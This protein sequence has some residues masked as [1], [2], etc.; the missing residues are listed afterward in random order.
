MNTKYMNSKTIQ[1]LKSTDLFQNIPE[2]DIIDFFK[3]HPV[4][5][6]YQKGSV[7]YLQN[8]LCETLDII[9]KGTVTIQKIDYD[10]KILT[11]N[12][13]CTG[14]ILGENL[15]FSTKNHYPMTVFAT[16]NTELVQIKAGAILD[17]CQRSRIFLQ[18]LLE[19]LSG[20]T[21]ILS[22]RLK[23]S[24]KSIRQILSEFL[25]YESYHQ[26]TLTIHL[27]SSK[28][29]LAEKMGIQRSSLSR[30]LN[31]MR[32][33]GLIEFDARTITIHQIDSLKD[34]L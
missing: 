24:V 31:K 25:I 3:D 1:L 20:K 23:S 10:G 19:S 30:E 7:I 9:L 34:L 5:R 6:K 4:I 12:Q 18:N 28:K 26:D 14:E 8:E 32:Q 15:L 33:D 17:C 16:S 13:F 21:L 2:E 22:D 29:E 11:I 27:P